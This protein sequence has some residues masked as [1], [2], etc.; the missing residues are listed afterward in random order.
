MAAMDIE[1][2][3]KRTAT[4]FGVQGPGV[5]KLPVDAILEDDH[6]VQDA[7][8]AYNQHAERYIRCRVKEILEDRDASD[9][10]SS[11]RANEAVEYIRAD[12]PEVSLRAGAQLAPSPPARGR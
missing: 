7:G 3:A 1:V 4:P 5:T 2:S 12:A 9:K 11:H 6:F 8:G 10:W